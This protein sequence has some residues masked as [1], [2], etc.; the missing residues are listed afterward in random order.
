MIL[1]FLV[2][3]ICGYCFSDS[4]ASNI[5][6][7]RYCG[8]PARDANGKIIRSSTVTR[9][10][11]LE[12]PCPVTGLPTGPCP[13]WQMDHIIPLVC[14]GCDEVSNLQWLPVEIKTAAGTLAKDRWEQRV[15]CK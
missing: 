12:H 3:L 2:A 5:D 1:G 6:E 15:Y 14:G 13:G 7:T 9:H 4:L 11:K 10:F 8:E